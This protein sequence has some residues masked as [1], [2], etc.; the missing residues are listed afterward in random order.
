[1]WN[2]FTCTKQYNEFT[3]S[4]VQQLSLL[5]AIFHLILFESQR[6]ATAHHNKPP[7]ARRGITSSCLALD[8]TC[9]SRREY[10][11]QQLGVDAVSSRKSIDYQLH[12]VVTIYKILSITSIITSICKYLMSN[13]QVAQM[14][15]ICEC[16]VDL[17]FGLKCFLTIC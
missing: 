7:V 3:N 4:A 1:M 15:S 8:S 13:I 6:H 5:F 11:D 17:F 14:P 10:W 16:F 2:R 12:R 9:I